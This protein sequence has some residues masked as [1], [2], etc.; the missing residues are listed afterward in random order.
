M[1]GNPSDDAACA[2]CLLLDHLVRY[3][4]GKRR[5]AVRAAD[6]HDVLV[7]LWLHK[8]D[9]AKAAAG[10]VLRAVL[11]D[12]LW[13]EGAEPYFVARDKARHTRRRHTHLTM[14]IPYLPRG[15]V[16]ALGG[17]VGEPRRT[18]PRPQSH[19]GRT[20]QMGHTHHGCTHTLTMA[21]PTRWA[22]SRAS[23]TR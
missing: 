15:A 10:K 14:G 12:R 16:L 19:H 5:P 17:W 13:M 1:R 21:V 6:V 8:A 9:A 20:H 7:P 11:S 22:S 2:G 18:V 4:K 23:C 3:Q